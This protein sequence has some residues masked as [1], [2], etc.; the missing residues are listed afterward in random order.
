[1][2]S[3]VDMF[4]LQEQ[5]LKWPFESEV[6]TT[7]PKVIKNSFLNVMSVLNWSKRFCTFTVEDLYDTKSVMM[8]LL[9]YWPSFTCKPLPHLA[10]DYWC[11]KSQTVFLSIRKSVRTST[12]MHTIAVNVDEAKRQQL[13]NYLQTAAVSE[14]TS[15][16]CTSA[17]VRL[18][19]KVKGR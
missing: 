5:G 11:H 6:G 10:A 16:C 7:Q 4:L 17:F 15:H 9:F 1:M 19:N 14:P 3:W 12:L 8:G 13:K 18:K 2:K